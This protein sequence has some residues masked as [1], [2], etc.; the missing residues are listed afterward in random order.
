MQKY[1]CWQR[2]P[3][4]LNV[5]YLISIFCVENYIFVPLSTDPMQKPVVTRP[6]V[7][8]QPHPKYFLHRS[9]SK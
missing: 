4:T 7:T 2:L 5:N 6:V 9:T 8:G 3:L 1:F